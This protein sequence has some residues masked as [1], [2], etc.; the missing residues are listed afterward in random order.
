MRRKLRLP[1]VLIPMLGIFGL[2]LVVNG[3]PAQEKE[4]GNEDRPRAARAAPAAPGA[5]AIMSLRAMERGSYLGVTIREVTEEDVE[6]LDLGEERGAL[7][8]EVPEE[9]PA[10]EAG[11]QADDVILSWNGSR[12][13]SAAQLRRVVGET[14]AGRTVDV[15]YA[16]DGD[17]RSVS[18]ELGDRPSPMAHWL[19]GREV[20][21]EARAR[22]EESLGR[23]RGQLRELRF[24]DGGFR[25]FARG[26][27]L[28][29]GI[30][31]LGDQ[32]AEYFGASDGGVLVTSVREE[33]AAAEAGLRAGD[34]I[35]RAGDEPVEDP[36]D[37]MREISRA[38]PGDFELRILRDGDERTMRVALPEREE[39]AFAPDHEGAATYFFEPGS[40][41]VG[42]WEHTFDALEE[43]ELPESLEFEL[44]LPSAAPAEPAEPAVRT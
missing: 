40:D 39:G 29:V 11:L 1:R 10:A 30:Q 26:G 8:A 13:E 41:A 31:S 16:R 9:G 4:Q 19:P 20:N 25:M 43:L 38:E 5:P 33:S 24:D 18:V 23:A 7:V 35:V 2:A 6:R 28:G 15:G 42:F 12:I 21:A 36:G 22:L 3:L 27:R 44:R 34:V 14:P 37:L 17:Q 32:L